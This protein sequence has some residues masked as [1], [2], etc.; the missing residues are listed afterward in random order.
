MKVLT[1]T[2]QVV[3]SLASLVSH[4]SS[5]P[6]LLDPCSLASGNYSTFPNAMACLSSFPLNETIKQAT[7][8][9]LKKALDFYVFKDLAVSFKDTNHELS[10]IT[11]NIDLIAE[12]DVI[13]QKQHSNDKA[14]HDDVFDLFLEL[15]DAHTRYY[16]TW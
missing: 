7:I 2:L 10:P 16:S 5:V 3:W 1:S 14:F 12:L 15:N 13:A 11:S 8:Q 4:V 9:T 6:L